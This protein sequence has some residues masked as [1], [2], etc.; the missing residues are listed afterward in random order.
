M[1]LQLLIKCRYLIQRDLL[2]LRESFV[3]ILRVLDLPNLLLHQ[4]NDSL[5]VSQCSRLLL[6]LILHLLTLL[7]NILELFLQLLDPVLQIIH[8]KS[9]SLS[10]FIGCCQLILVFRIVL[11]L[12]LTLSHDLILF[13]FDLC[14]YLRNRYILIIEH[15]ILNL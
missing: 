1:S 5:L 13:S 4:L 8:T 11:G 9:L 10:L 3:L 14:L 2:F 15:P 12:F 7:S 6:Q